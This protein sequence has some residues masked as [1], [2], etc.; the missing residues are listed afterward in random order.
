MREIAVAAAEFGV[1]AGDLGVVNLDGA[2]GVAPQPENGVLQLE[3]RALIV[4]ADDEQRCHAP[5]PFREFKRSPS[6]AGRGLG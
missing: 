6:P 3:T 5:R 2:D 1:V 4:S